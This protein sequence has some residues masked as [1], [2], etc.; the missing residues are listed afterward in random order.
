[1][2]KNLGIRGFFCSENFQNL[3]TGGYEQN[4]RTAKDIAHLPYGC[5]SS[6]QTGD[7]CGRD[8]LVGIYVIPSSTSTKLHHKKRKEKADSSKYYFLYASQE[9]EKKKKAESSKY[10]FL[11]DPQL[12]NLGVEIDENKQLCA[13][14]NLF[15]KAS[16]MVE[17]GVKRGDGFF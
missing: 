12:T 11:Y 14:L 10:Y 7:N 1:M 16:Q 5:Y 6:N 13:F 8:V 15:T 2:F 9:K 17:R 4:Q 3:R